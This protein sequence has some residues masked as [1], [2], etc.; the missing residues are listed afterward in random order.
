MALIGGR[1]ASTLG[2]LARRKKTG[3]ASRPELASCTSSTCQV[4]H[5]RMY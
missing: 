2:S 5:S 3:K 4:G 1:D